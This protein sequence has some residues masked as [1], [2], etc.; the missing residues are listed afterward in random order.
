VLLLR[1]DDQ[2]YLILLSPNGDVI[3]D[4]RIK[5]KDDP[6]APATGPA[7]PTTKTEPAP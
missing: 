7:L 3:L 5:A 2:E 6:E 1:R 4:D